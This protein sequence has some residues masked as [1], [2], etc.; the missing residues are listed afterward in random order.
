[1]KKRGQITVFIVVGIIVILSGFLIFY[2]MRGETEIDEPSLPLRPQVPAETTPVYNFVE[3]CM[4]DLT[5]KALKEVMLRGGYIYDD[6]LNKHPFESTEG[7][8]VELVPT[9][10]ILIPFWYYMKSNNECT[11]NCQFDSMRKPLCKYSNTVCDY[12]G[13][14]SIENEIEL[15][16]KNN[17]DSCINDFSEIEITGLEVNPLLD[18]EFNVYIRRDSLLVELEYPLEIIDQNQINEI[19]EFRIQKQTNLY[20]LYEIAYEITKYQQDYCFL[21]E[22]ILNIISLHSGLNEQP[23]PPFSAST[24]D[25]FNLFWMKRDVHSQLDYLTYSYMPLIRLFNTSVDPFPQVAQ[26]GQFMQ[27]IVDSFLYFPLTKFRDVFPSFMYY[28]YHE[29]YFDIFPNR[30]ELIGP[31]EIFNPSDNPLARMLGNIQTREYEFKYRYSFPVIVELRKFKGD[32]SFQN[33]E[34]FRFAL[35]GNIRAN[36]CFNSDANIVGIGNAPSLLCDPLFF[37]NKNYTFNLINDYTNEPIENVHIDFFAEETC[38]IGLT[39]Q[40]GQLLTRIP[41]A[42]QGLLI[43]SKE[44]YLDKMILTDN[45]FEQNTIRLKPLFE[46]NVSINLVND[47]LL[48]EF[49]FVQNWQNHRKEYSNQMRENMSVLIQIERNKQNEFDTDYSQTVYLDYGDEQK[50]RLTKGQYNVNIMLILNEDIILPEERNMICIDTSVI[51][52]FSTCRKVPINDE[53]YRPD[54]CDPW[55]TNLERDDLCFELSDCY[56]DGFTCSSACDEEAEIIYDEQ[57]LPS[58]MVGG[59]IINETNGLWNINNYDLLNNTQNIEF[60]PYYEGPPERLTQMINNLNK[61]MDYSI[62]YGHYLRPYFR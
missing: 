56:I 3:Q 13:T 58:I 59:L 44:G 33:M 60:Y 27:G 43:F 7:N 38:N 10:N 2:L 5:E 39:N 26:G 6:E 12:R 15:Y 19:N 24:N 53:C 21:D 31:S 22:H 61:Y 57:L 32:Y 30:G 40:S 50:L 34:T 52:W 9:T 8:A 62:T 35:E 23:L 48:N 20:D 17:L 1:M 51:Q 42:E 25:P 37:V 14:N 16:L 54:F 18:P 49:S 36:R 28:P 55:P 29:T 47:D 11:T 45:L 4:N 46:H 41:S